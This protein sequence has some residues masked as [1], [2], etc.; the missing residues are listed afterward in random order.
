MES[1]ILSASPVELVHIL[2]QAALNSVREARRGLAEGDITAR[3]QAISKA[4]EILIELSSSL[5]YA[6]GGQLSERLGN[7]YQYMQHRF[8]QANLEQS[9]APLVEILGL[10]TTL[11][12][13]WQGVRSFASQLPSNGSSADAPSP[14]N[15]GMEPVAEYALQG[16]LY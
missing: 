5:N 6:E 12:D 13:A 9:D 16:L 4:T 10:L 3:S 15:F 11:Y 2:Y 14:P 7:L 1:R 8:L